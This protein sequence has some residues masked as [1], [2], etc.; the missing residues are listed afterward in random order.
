MPTQVSLAVV[1]HPLGCALRLELSP[2]LERIQPAGVTRRALYYGV[3]SCTLWGDEAPE[4][5]TTVVHPIT[6]F[7]A[8]F[9]RR[10]IFITFRAIQ[11]GRRAPM[12]SKERL[13]QSAFKA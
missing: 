5:S 11:A 4:T 7:D 13:Y 9:V 1:L 10:Y 2:L 6:A 8:L 12:T 3:R